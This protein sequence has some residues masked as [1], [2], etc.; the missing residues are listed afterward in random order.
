[1]SDVVLLSGATIDSVDGCARNLHRQTLRHSGAAVPSNGGRA[2]CVLTVRRAAGALVR[3]AIAELVS[4]GF[5]D[6]P[7]LDWPE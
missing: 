1:V 5:R 2:P 7:V 6:R 3:L 4:S